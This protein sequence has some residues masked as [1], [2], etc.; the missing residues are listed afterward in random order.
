L[1]YYDSVNITESRLAFRQQC[2]DGADVDY[3]QNHHDW[4][5]QVFGC[6]V[7]AP[8]VQTVGGVACKQG[9]L[10]TFPNI[11]QHRVQPFGLEDHTKP[12]HRKILALFLVDPN[13]R[14]IS[15]AN[16]PSQRRD[17]WDEMM[18]WNAVLGRLPR[19]LQ[20]QVLSYL[21]EFPITM[22]EAKKLRLEL[23]EERSSLSM[24]QNDAFTDATFSLC[25]H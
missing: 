11:L 10:L 1:Y 22:G 8:T 14:V 3:E 15:T 6:E 18:P 9:R 24:E 19:E 20:D 21:E 2:S 13:I 23:M 17:W 16:V 25:E 12:G 5:P 7:D 4:L